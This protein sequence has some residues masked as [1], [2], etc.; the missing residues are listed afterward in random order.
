MIKNINNEG[1]KKFINV[2]K[3]RSKSKDSNNKKNIK[4]KIIENPL[5][6]FINDLNKKTLE[7]TN[8]ILNKKEKYENIPLLP[9]K[10]IEDDSFE[11]IDSDKLIFD[12]SNISDNEEVKNNFCFKLNNDEDSLEEE[13]VFIIQNSNNNLEKIKKNLIFYIKNFGLMI[14]K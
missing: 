3:S 1:F 7:A 5:N 6:D 4:K 12:N 14:N 13:K 8:K 9:K 10:N 2:N 11:I